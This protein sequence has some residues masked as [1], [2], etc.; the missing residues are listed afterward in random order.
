MMND[1]KPLEKYLAI[2][3]MVIYRLITQDEKTQHDRDALFDELYNQ[4][5]KVMTD[6]A[7]K[8]NLDL[9]N[10]LRAMKDE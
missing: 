5:I 3:K 1:K 10:A 4:K 7:N 2:Y 9:S 8:Y 6:F